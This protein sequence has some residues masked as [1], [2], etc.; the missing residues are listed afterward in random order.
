MKGRIVFRIVDVYK[1]CLTHWIIFACIWDRKI[2]EKPFFIF[3]SFAFFLLFQKKIVILIKCWC[4]L[5]VRISLVMNDRFDNHLSWSCRFIYRVI[6]SQRIGLEHV[7]DSSGC[8]MCI[9]LSSAN[10]CNQ[11][12]YI[13]FVVP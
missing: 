6:M 10:L 5:K 2:K 3:R 9:N 11:Y 13:R 4:S 8:G 7:P 1:R 12:R